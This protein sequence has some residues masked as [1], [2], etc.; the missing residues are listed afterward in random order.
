MDITEERSVTIAE[1][2]V[3]D[4]YSVGLKVR[5]RSLELTPDQARALAFALN[6]EAD[7]AETLQ[8]TDMRANETKLR[9]E[10]VREGIN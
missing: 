1:T 8:D 6:E 7:A 10:L 9:S 2:E 5:R 4:R 3:T